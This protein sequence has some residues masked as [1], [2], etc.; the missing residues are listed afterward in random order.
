L[1]IEKDVFE[2]FNKE[3]GEKHL[4]V[5]VWCVAIAQMAFWFFV[6]SMGGIAAWA[7][8]LYVIM[9]VWVA[10]GQVKQL[11][12]NHKTMKYNVYDLIFRQFIYQ[13]ILIAGGFYTHGPLVNF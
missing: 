1:A 10:H 5:L 6:I 3:V 9:T 7:L 13:A 12:K 4:P 11:L 8:G 2:K